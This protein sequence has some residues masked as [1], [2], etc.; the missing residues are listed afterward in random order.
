MV[1][2]SIVVSLIDSHTLRHAKIRSSFVFQQIFLAPPTPMEHGGKD[3]T[4]T[5]SQHISASPTIPWY[6]DVSSRGSGWWGRHYHV[7][8][9]VEISMV[10]SGLEGPPCCVSGLA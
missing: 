1:Y 2:I 8:V 7:A 3:Y 4:C 5:V 9:G 10:T 6:P